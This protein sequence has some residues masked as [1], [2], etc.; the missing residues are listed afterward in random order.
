MIILI[1]IIETQK[2]KTLKKNHILKKKIDYDDVETPPS[3]VGAETILDSTAHTD[4]PPS[5]NG[6]NWTVSDMRLLGVQNRK[7]PHS[8][9]GS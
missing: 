1:I 2:K 7:V 9:E 6:V 4:N 8:A 5:V 3:N